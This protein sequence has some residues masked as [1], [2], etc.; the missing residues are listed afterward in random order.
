VP[1]F[2]LLSVLANLVA[3][4]T[5]AGD[6]LGAKFAFLAS[7]KNLR[8]NR[9]ATIVIAVAAAVIGLLKLVILSP[10]E[11][12]PVA[13][14]L[15]PALAGIVLGVILLAEVFRERVE[16]RG[17]GIQKLSKLALSYRVPVG[18]AG[19]VIALAHFLLPGAVIL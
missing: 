1:Q 19:V 13:G 2:Y 14:D 12:V 18:I 3:G 11:S 5:L 15:L 7:F 9:P 10:R 16:S 4:L 17:Q 6:Y 8:D